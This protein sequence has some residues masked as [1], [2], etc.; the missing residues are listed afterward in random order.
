MRQRRREPAPNQ[1]GNI[2]APRLHPKVREPRQQWNDCV[3]KLQRSP[4]QPPRRTASISNSSSPAWKRQP[5]SRNRG[6]WGSQSARQAHI[7]LLT[8][9]DESANQ[10]A[11]ARGARFASELKVALE[12]TQQAL[13][14]GDQRA[15]HT[16]A[17]AQNTQ[18]EANIA[19]LE[20]QQRA[21]D[22]AL[23]LLKRDMS[24]RVADSDRARILRVLRA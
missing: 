9:E 14:A 17:A 23:L 8:S 18:A 21:S 3:S 16:L 13:Q 24:V 2:C 6:K 1:C 15:Q 20:N 4:G 5:S 7:A 11:S 19:F 22:D 10:A 12:R